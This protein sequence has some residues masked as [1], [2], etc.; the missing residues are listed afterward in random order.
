M[1][2]TTAT[3]TPTAPA[4]PTA[5]AT[6]TATPIGYDNS[7]M[8]LR[9]REDVIS[10]VLGVIGGSIYSLYHLVDLTYYRASMILVL[11]VVVYKFRSVS[12]VVLKE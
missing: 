12:A 10:T 1:T 11:A 9:C 2:S 4:I 8:C 5:T 6:A 3:A 7:E